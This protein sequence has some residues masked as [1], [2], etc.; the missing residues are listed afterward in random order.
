MPHI[1]QSENQLKCL[2]TIIYRSYTEISYIKGHPVASAKFN[3]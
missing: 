2:K 1:Y 3:Q